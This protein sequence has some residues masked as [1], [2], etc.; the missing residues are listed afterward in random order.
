MTA[1]QT[2]DMGFIRS[3]IAD[4]LQRCLAWSTALAAPQRPTS[5]T[6]LLAI[7]EVGEGSTA[8]RV[9]TDAG[10]TTQALEPFEV[11][12][13]DAAGTRRGLK[14]VVRLPSGLSYGGD[15]ERA[16][17]LAAELCIMDKRHVITT[18][19]LFLALVMRDRA[20]QAALIS[21]GADPSA[22]RSQV[23]RSRTRRSEA[24]RRR[25]RRQALE[26]TAGWTDFLCSL[27]AYVLHGINLREGRTADTH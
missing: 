2:D 5:V 26:Q 1:F 15:G 4:D 14:G 27:T 10:V 24:E 17:R 12:A 23:A 21:L 8:Q 7:L 3:N 22:M 25:R 20:A 11:A 18:D 6:L 13:R 19:D 9:M 16:I